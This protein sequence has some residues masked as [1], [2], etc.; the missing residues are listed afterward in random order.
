LGVELEGKELSEFLKGA[1]N[2]LREDIIPFQPSANRN[3]E[4]TDYSLG[5]IV[6]HLG[7]LVVGIGEMLV[8]GTGDAGAAVA[9]V[10]SLG[11]GA[12]VA[13]PVA[14]GAT[15]LIGLGANTTGKALMNLNSSGEKTHQTYTKPDKNGG[16][17]YSGKTSGTGRPEDNVTKRD[18][19]H[20]M[21]K[22][23][24]GKAVLDRSSKSADAIR[25]R[26]QNLIDANGGSKSTGGTSGNQNNGISPK[27]KNAEKYKQAALNE[28]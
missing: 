24:F 17:P 4:S 6:G 25:G 27:N 23:G 1:N 3:F 10:G 21:N 28:F 5:K 7:G 9:T 16:Q 12:I 26:E 11:A 15:A 14:I 20:H 8:G 22:K 19:N 18:A 2:A 13:A